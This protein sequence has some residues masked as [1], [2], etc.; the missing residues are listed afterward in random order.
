MSA[1][2]LLD[3]EDGQ[4]SGAS[5][6]SKAMG[7]VRMATMAIV[8]QSDSAPNGIHIAIGG[9]MGAA[10][11]V[12]GMTG[13]PVPASSKDIEALAMHPDRRLFALLL[14]HASY[15][16]CDDTINAQLGPPVYL[17]AM[18]MFEKLTGRKPDGL[19][20]PM[21]VQAA[22]DYERDPKD[23]NMPEVVDVHYA[24]EEEGRIHG[25]H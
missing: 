11:L 14:A 1:N 5:L 21:L 8:S 19:L 13:S 24:T 15:S 17:D 4:K 6:Y 2:P 16:E 10:R 12:A 22:R 9:V 23:M 3:T 25:K 7:I 18:T 20:N